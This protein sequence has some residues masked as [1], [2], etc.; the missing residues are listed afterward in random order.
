MHK[1]LKNPPL[2]YVLAQVKMSAIEN[3][4]KYI[5]ELQ[6][7][8]R[9][10]FPIYNKVEI[11]SVEIRQGHDPKANI[12]KTVQWHFKDKKA[13]MGIILD[14]NT[15]NVHT[16]K[17]EGFN[18]FIEQIEH[19]LATFNQQLDIDLSTKIGLR[20]VNVIRSDVENFLRKE[21]LGFH[22]EDSENNFLSKAETHQQINDEYIKI[23]TTYIGNSKIIEPNRNRLV[24]NDLAESVRGLSFEHHKKPDNKYAFLD[25]DGSCGNPSK[26]TDFKLQNIK[27]VLTKLHNN[28]YEAFS[29]A[30]TDKAM[31][32]WS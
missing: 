15:I 13:L 9:K 32:G 19:I 20:Y 17:Y 12:T 25:I 6:D 16:S 30:I 10:E 28:I 3:L 23:K 26:P 11:Q 14:S 4:V 1:K 31:K 18:T 7:S 5:P 2:T 24:P 22:L 8:I 27:A 21:L 29:G